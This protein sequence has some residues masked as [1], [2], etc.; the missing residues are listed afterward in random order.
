MAYEIDHFMI[1]QIQ[2]D[3]NLNLVEI[4]NLERNRN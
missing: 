4:D 2:G 1:N 3:C